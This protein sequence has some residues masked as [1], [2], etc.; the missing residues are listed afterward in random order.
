M[1]TDK[2]LKIVSLQAENVKRIQAVRIDPTGNLV[3]ITGRNGQGK[4]SVLD[5]IWWALKGAGVVQR[6][7]IRA[8]QERAKITLDMGA[9]IATRHFKRLEDGD[10][11]THLEVMTEGGGMLSSPQKAVDGL[12]GKLAIDPL[13]FA[14]MKPAD[15]FDTLKGFVAGYDFA[16]EAAA[17]LADRTKR[18]EVNRVAGEK[19][20]QAAAIAIPESVPAVKVDESALIDELAAVGEHNAT[21][22]RR[23]EGR[24]LV[25]KEARD[26]R[27]AAAESRERAAEYRRKAEELDE[28]SSSQEAE[29]VAREEKLATAKPLPAPKDAAEVRKRLE[30]AKRTNAL[31]DQ[32]A[33]RTALKAEAE[34]YEKQSEGITERINQREAA[35]RAAISEAKLP[36]EGIG[37][38]AGFITLNGVPFDQASDAEQLRA[39]VSIA[40]AAKPRLRVI[41]IRDGSLLDDDGLR[42]IAEM[43]DAADYQVWVERVDSSGK[44]GFV[45]DDGMVRHAP[46]APPSQQ[47]A[48]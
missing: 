19:A 10:Y 15:Q 22:E 25:A 27:A 43:A 44:V 38:G 3:E 48:E 47:A 6:S 45:I 30:E 37:F 17:D 4:T 12:L 26:F 16:G 39:S 7:P 14:N 29:A 31:V 35:K 42:L 20:T 2:P 8:G 1:T 5:S 46:E 28:Q 36:V 13:E 18:T 33:R 34:A 24:E 41:R 40:M 23:K 21:I 32:A 9:L 11:S